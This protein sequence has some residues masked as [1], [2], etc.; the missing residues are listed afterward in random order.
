MTDL[1][2][3]KRRRGLLVQGVRSVRGGL[4]WLLPGALE[5][6]GGLVITIG[7]AVGGAVELGFALL[8]KHVKWG[9]PQIGLA[10]VV[11]GIIRAGMVHDW[12]R[13]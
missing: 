11:V 3:W 2:K 4:S 12:F 8:G 13:R 10:G 7:L 5:G 9:P 6:K 1:Q